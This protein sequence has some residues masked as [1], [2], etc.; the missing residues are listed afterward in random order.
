MNKA[1]TK[2]R[3]AEA[4]IPTPRYEVVRAATVSDVA[5]RWKTPVVVK[6]ICSGSSVDTY[7]CRDRDSFAANLEQV[8]STYGAALVE[9]CIIGPELTVGVLGDQALPVCEIRTAREFY[10]Y[11][12]KYVDDDTQY[13]FDLG[14]PPRVLEM[15]QELSVK[16]CRVTGCVDLAR[17]DWMVDGATLDPYALEINTIPGFTSHSLV[18][19]SAARVGISFDQLCQRIVDLGMDRRHKPPRTP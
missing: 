2:A 11:Q 10:D 18:P 13:L 9:Q 5:A 4:A 17:V 3:L 16:A 12:A 19:K 1:A 15:V 6:P 8:V 14:L 7:I